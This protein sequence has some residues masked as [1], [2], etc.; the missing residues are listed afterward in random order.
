[1]Y[2]WCRMSEWCRMSD[3]PTDRPSVRPSVL[4]GAGVAARRGVA[5]RLFDARVA[6]HHHGARDAMRCDAMR[7]DAWDGWMDGCHGRAWMR[8]AAHGVRSRRDRRRRR[9]RDGARDGGFGVL[10]GARAWVRRDW[11]GRRAR[12]R[13]GARWCVV[14]LVSRRAGVASASPMRGRDGDARGMTAQ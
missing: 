2:G 14:V 1:M 3:R 9:W 13:G 7:R 12:A 8:M 10:P 6:V 4:V 5:G 11:G